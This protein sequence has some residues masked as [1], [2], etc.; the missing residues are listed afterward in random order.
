V[1][2]ASA[3]DRMLPTAGRDL[4]VLGQ[5]GT[6]ASGLLHC[7][8]LEG[9]NALSSA[10]AAGVCGHSLGVR[11]SFYT[12]ADS[13]DDLETLRIRL[14]APQIALYAVSYGTR[15]AVEYA[16]RYPQRVERMILDSPVGIDAPDSLARETLG[17]VGR[18]LRGVCRYGC[19][20]A[21]AHPVADMARLVAMLRRSPIRR[22]MHRGRRRAPVSV[23][24]DDL[25]GM[26]VPATSI[27]RSCAGS[28]RRCA[29]PWP[30][31]AGRSSC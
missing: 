22:V 25:L 15:V 12:S 2:F 7:P 4:V 6:G 29:P 26:L 13:A 8:S 5:R 24:V 9:R 30:V 27:P 1:I 21:G 11:R 14:G 20:R 23:G 17:A 19:G 31:T 16:R 28:R 18:V 10:H 3:Y